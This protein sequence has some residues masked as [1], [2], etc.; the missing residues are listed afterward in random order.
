VLAIGGTAWAR[1]SDGGQDIATAPDIP[2]SEEV[3]GGSTDGHPEFWRLML[4]RADHVRLDFGT[5]SG[6]GVY[7][8]VF[9]PNVTDFTVAQSDCVASY[10]QGAR[11]KSELKYV[12]PG[13]GKY[14]LRLQNRYCCDAYSYILEVYVRHYTTATVAAPRFVIKGRPFGVRGSVSGVAGGRVQL[15][16]YA[17]GRKW[18]SRPVSLSSSGKFK[19]ALRLARK[20]RCTLRV[21]YSGDATHLPSGASTVVRVVSG[22]HVK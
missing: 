19:V 20:C 9:A 1:S 13:P 12:A 4:R 11:E 17:H 5:T 14:T 21:L 18:L 15:R 16:I 7:L 2:V 8:C 10:A 22:S 6:D 3:Q